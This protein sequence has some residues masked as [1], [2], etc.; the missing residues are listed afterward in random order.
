[1][2]AALT[3]QSPKII[4]ANKIIEESPDIK[5]SSLAEKLGYHI[6]TVLKWHASGL[7]KLTS[8][9]SR[10]ARFCHDNR[11]KPLSTKIE[12]MKYEDA[13]WVPQE[14]AQYFKWAWSVTGSNGIACSGA[15][16]GNKKDAEVSA[17]AMAANMTRQYERGD[18]GTFTI[19]S[20]EART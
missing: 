12:I 8:I 18:N 1:M 16:R 5:A 20:T 6:G 9:K 13:P 15:V 10:V 2:N 19:I 3:L 14:Y 17:K 4:K 11:R 7:I